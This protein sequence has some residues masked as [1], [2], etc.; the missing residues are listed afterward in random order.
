M[1]TARSSK[2]GD[3]LVR[4]DRRPY[5]I[6]RD[7][8]QADLESATQEV[9]ASSA[10]VSAAQATLARAQSDLD[11]VRIQTERVL[12]LEVKGLVPIARAD[13][14]RGE[15]A[16]AEADLENAMADLER[17]KQTLG[18][19]GLDN[20]KIQHALANLADAELNLEW[21]EL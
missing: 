15:L 20:P 11:T 16:E 17:A 14:A 6:A 13:E 10:E 1:K 5:E 9:G 7:K 8:A 12:A 2:R 21:T 18:D 3:V 4:I 19:D